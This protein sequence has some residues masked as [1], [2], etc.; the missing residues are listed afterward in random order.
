MNQMKNCTVLEAAVSSIE[1]D[2][3]FDPSSDRSA[4]HLPTTG[5]IR[6]QMVTLDTLVSRMQIRPPN[7]M[8][9]GIEGGEYES[10]RGFAHSIR[11]FQP[12]IF[13]PTHGCDVH[14]VC[15]TLLTDWNYPIGSLDD[16][17]PQTSRE[18]VATAGIDRKGRYGFA[19][20]IAQ[21]TILWS[22]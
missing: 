3:S 15:L 10:L 6:V 17:P 4:A 20:G 8:K 12:V 2:A 5:N 22:A 19:S 16:L 21:Y 14:S 18:L 7:L 9:I 13:L 11:T 1:G